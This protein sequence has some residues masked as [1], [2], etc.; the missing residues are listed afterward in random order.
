MFRLRKG[1]E[2]DVGVLK[3][4]FSTRWVDFSDIKQTSP[5]A[6]YQRAANHSSAYT[7]RNAPWD[8]IC[9]PVV[10]KYVPGR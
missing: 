7:I 6:G 2:V 9:I 5:F 3:L 1:H 4:F 8:S 10:Q